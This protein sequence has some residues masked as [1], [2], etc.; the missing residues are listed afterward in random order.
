MPEP[1][2][3]E[4][5]AGYDRWS[6]I[7]DEDPNPLKHL[8]EP[9]VRAWIPVAEGMRVADVGCGTGRHALWLAESGAR[10]E[11]FDPS[12]G[13][14]GKAREKLAQLGIRVQA[15]CLPDPLPV[16]D[17]V[18]DL[19]LLALVGDHLKD[20]QAGFRELHRITRPGGVVVFTVLHPAMNLRGLTARFTDPADGREVRV[21]AFEHTYADYV[22]AVLRAGLHIDE[23][24]ERKVDA[25]L[26]AAVPRAAKYLDW[27]MLLAM[28][29]RKPS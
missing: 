6:I 17:K 7:Y 19:V 16:E 15:H 24:I 21:A 10:V 18:F 4:T 11:A 22:M 2:H 9:I 27:P 29:L 14:R 23:I 3:M 26:A 12:A 20:L 25:S 5:Q 1:K 28:R 8:E 13:M